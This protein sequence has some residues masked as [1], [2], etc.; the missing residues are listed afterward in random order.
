MRSDNPSRLAAILTLRPNGEGGNERRIM[1]DIPGQIHAALYQ[2]CRIFLQW[3]SS[4]CMSPRNLSS[5]MG[6]G[7]ERPDRFRY[8]VSSYLYEKSSHEV[9]WQSL[10]H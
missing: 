3:M 9:R 10:P 2:T 5:L 4:Q 7:G 8:L 6:G 1:D